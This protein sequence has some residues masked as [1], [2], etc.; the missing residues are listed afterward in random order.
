MVI[1]DRERLIVKLCD[2]GLSTFMRPGRLLE[3]NCGTVMYGMVYHLFICIY[4][5]PYKAAPELI[6]CPNGYGKEVDIWSLGVLLFTA[7]VAFTPFLQRSEAE[8]HKRETIDQIKRGDFNFDCS[9]W[10][11]ISHEG[12]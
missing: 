3:T 8:E 5:H 2:F 10:D 9:V 6:D 4:T 1:F 12:K 11:D 7:L